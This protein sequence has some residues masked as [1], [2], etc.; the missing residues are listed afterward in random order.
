MRAVIDIL[1]Y[2]WQLPQNLVGLSLP[3]FYRTRLRTLDYKG[4]KVCIYDN[5]PGGVSLGKYIH[6]DYYRHYP[7]EEQLRI[8]LSDSIKHEYGHCRQSERW[9]WLYLP[10]PGLVS[11]AHNLLCKCIKHKHKSYFNVWP[12]NEADR[13]GGVTRQ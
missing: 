8:S 3:L 13:L 1:L 4:K 2:V 10:G 5:F 9:G 12:E 11:G 7:S 6:L